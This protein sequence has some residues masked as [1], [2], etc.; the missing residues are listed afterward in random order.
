[1][2]IDRALGDIIQKAARQPCLTRERVAEA[3]ANGETLAKAKLDGLNLA[4]LDFSG[5]DLSDATLRGANLSDA[6]LDHA[7]LA[8]AD[9]SKAVLTNTNFA[10]GPRPREF[11]RGADRGMVPSR[12]PRVD[13][14]VFAKLDLTGA[15]FKA[16]RP[17]G[18]GDFSDAI[19]D[20]ARFT[21]ANL[22]RARFTAASAAAADFSNAALP[23]ADFSGAKAA[24]IVMEGADLTNLRASRKADFSD[25]R[26]A[27]VKAARSVWQQAVL[28]RAGFDRGR[29]SKFSTFRSI[30]AGG[31]FRSR[32]SARHE[33]RRRRPDR[34]DDHQFQ[35]APRLVQPRHLTNASVEGCNLYSA[36]LLDATL[37]GAS[38][39]GS[40]VM[41][42]LLAR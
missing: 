40:M 28:D 2:E 7:R 6:L 18:D 42:T 10:G 32:A 33:F 34:S 31:P 15:G 35:P 36:G 41:L 20:G 24:G 12:V 37:E 21:N 23:A 5:A 39:Q 9:L 17:A 26:F 1:M 14:A 19:L 8:G 11:H 30:V 3:L 16:E 4:A 29:C 13:E 38:F 27:H 22:P 25:G